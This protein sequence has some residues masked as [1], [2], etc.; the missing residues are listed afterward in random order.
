[1]RERVQP[2]E[3]RDLVVAQDFF[4]ALR[5]VSLDLGILRVPDVAHDAAERLAAL[6]PQA[7]VLACDGIKHHGIR[8]RQLDL[9]LLV[10]RAFLQ[11]RRLDE[12][13]EAAE[14]LVA[15]RD[16]CAIFHAVIAP[17][18][19][20]IAEDGEDLVEV[21]VFRRERDLEQVVLIH[22]DTGRDFRH[23]LHGLFLERVGIVDFRF[24]REH[25]Q[26][27]RQ[28]IIALFFVILHVELAVFFEAIGI[29][30]VLNLL[31]AAVIAHED[32]TVLFLLRPV[33]DDRVELD[34]LIRKHGPRLDA[35]AMVV[36]INLRMERRDLEFLRE[37]IRDL[38]L[39]RVLHGGQ[40]FAEEGL[41]VLRVQMEVFRFF[42]CLDCRLQTGALLLCDLV[43]RRIFRR[44]EKVR[45]RR[46][47]FQD[48]DVRR[49]LKGRAVLPFI[50]QFDMERRDVMHEMRIHGFIILIMHLDGLA[51]TN[52]EKFP[53]ECLRQFESLLV[54]QKA[55][56][57][58][59]IRKTS[60]ILHHVAL[61]LCRTVQ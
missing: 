21:D 33:R 6:E 13:R 49:D 10:G 1:M 4:K 60:A 37:A 56:A 19:A 24:F 26:R 22:R 53:E 27:F 47:L 39:D 7:F 31:L 2:I 30:T 9:V 15:K 41:E 8:E 18:L 35:V 44:V 42:K 5:H 14:L 51:V 11:P 29:K 57:I 43:E 55:A 25:G 59:I 23:R 52:R 3:A 34:A 38:D 40:D 48:A 12:I 36:E 17:L 54:E 46:H 28:E 50:R 45:L 61:G 20:I 32:A 16:E 58:A